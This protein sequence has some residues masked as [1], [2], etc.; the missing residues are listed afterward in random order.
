MAI[1]RG[2]ML[3]LDAMINTNIYRNDDYGVYEV[4]IKNMDEL[5]KED[6]K[7]IIPPYEYATISGKFDRPMYHGEEYIFYVVP[8]NHE[9]YGM[10]YIVQ[11]TKNKFDTPARVSA[12][13][14]QFVADN[15]ADQ[16]IKEYGSELIQ[17][18]ID[19]EVDYSKIHGMGEYRFNQMRDKVLENEYMQEIIMELGEYGI[20]PLQMRNIVE[21]FGNNAVSIIKENPYK[22]CLVHGI[23]FKR[24]DDIAKNMGYDM[25][26]PNRIREAIKYCLSENEN[27]GN[28]WV[29]QKE[30]LYEVADLTK[31]Q[32]KLINEQLEEGLEGVLILNRRVTLQK[33]YNMEC[34]IAD[35]CIE[36]VNDKTPLNFNVD[37]FIKEIEA[38]GVIL[39]EEQRQF[40]HNFHDN[41]INLLV[42]Y[43]GCGKSFL[44]KYVL[45]IADRLN[46]SKLLI[47]PTGKAS[48]VLS[49]YTGYP[50]STLHRAFKYG[51]GSEP[52]GTY[53]D[54]YIFD[55]GSMG[56]IPM[57]RVLLQCMKNP[58]A[59]VLIVGDDFQL[60]S[61][62]VGNVLSDMIRSGVIPTT[63]LTKVFRQAEGGLLD[64]VTKIRLGEKFL[65]DT[66]EGKKEVRNR[67]AYSLYATVVNGSRL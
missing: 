38:E 49:S 20:T 63:K 65:P 40:L 31:V 51:R 60:P 2:K 23:G 9:K 44:Q 4:V 52:E 15:I 48:K 19:N 64:I 43:A 6:D 56:D 37:E 25:N 16:L 41:R 7:T 22:L 34:Y 32:K 10:Q 57:Y 13:I 53:H 14:R 45:R 27:K 47:A 39:T 29:D 67:L 26:S 42:G 17:K 59:R 3:K 1:E 55:E 36:L 62:G 12:F 54:L 21:R 24:A 5:M 30:L 28:S 46:M 66:F 8:R 11:I 18:I 33:T 35:R 58:K 61:V 50:A